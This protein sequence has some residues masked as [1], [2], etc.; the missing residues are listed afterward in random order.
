MKQRED[1]RL[2]STTSRP[3]AL[4]LPLRAAPATVRCGSCGCI[5]PS[6]VLPVAGLHR[7]DDPAVF[8]VKLAC[9]AL[10]TH[11][12]H[13]HVA[14]MARSASKHASSINRRSDAYSATQQASYRAG[15]GLVS[16]LLAS[17]YMPMHR[18]KLSDE[19]QTGR[20]CQ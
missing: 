14:A 4:Q 18:W 5:S 10:M 17:E 20:F 16:Q 9:T 6:S 1:G 12:C 11:P 3:A 8:A 13:G 19:W 2:N 15:F 7:A